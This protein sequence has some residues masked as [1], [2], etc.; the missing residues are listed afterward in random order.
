MSGRPGTPFICTRNRY[1]IA[2]SKL[3]TVS[4]GLVSARLIRDITALRCSDL[5]ESTISLTW[6]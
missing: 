6:E 3:R 4:S 1:P 5:S 2:Y